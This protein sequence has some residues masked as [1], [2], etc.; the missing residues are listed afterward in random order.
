MWKSVALYLV[1]VLLPQIADG[2]GP[3]LSTGAWFRMEIRETGIYKLDRNFFQNANVPNFSSINAIRIFGGDGKALNENPGGP[4]PSAMPEVARYVVDRNNN[5][6]FDAEDFVLFYGRS[7]RWWTYNASTRSFS[8]YLNYYTETNVYYFTFSAGGTPNVMDTIRSEQVSTP[9]QALDVAGKIAVE[10]ELFKLGTNS[11]REWFGRFLNRM[12]NSTTYTTM[13]DGI[14]QTKPILYRFVILSR[15]S[16]VDTFR[17][18]ESGSPLGNPT[19]MFPVDVTSIEGNFAYR[20]P[21]ITATHTGGIPGGRSSLRF[22]FGTR[23]DAAEA[24]IDWFEIHYRQRLEAI[25]DQLVFHTLDTTGIV[26]Y[27]LS[28]FSSGEK[29]VFDVT[30]HAN[31]KRITGIMTLPSDRDVILFQLNQSAGTVR[32]IAVVGQNGFRTPA[33]VARVPNS[34]LREITQGAEFV[35]ISPAEFLSEANRL[36]THRERVNP[37]ST[38][39]VDIQSLFN[40]YSFGIADPTAIRNF[41]LDARAR[42]TRRVNYV[43]LFGDGHYDYKNIRTTTKNW[44]PPYE[45]IESVQQILTYTTDDYFVRLNAGTA[46]PTLRIGRLPIRNREEAAA[47]V[48]KIIR[49]ETAAPFDTWR[50]R[51]TFVADDGLTSTRDDGNI[52][53]LQ[54]DLLA[55][56]YTPRSFEREKIYIVEYPTVNS[57]VG[58]RKPDAN[59]AIIDAFNRGTLIVNFVGH[60]NTKVWTHEAV[61]TQD[62]SFA[63]LAN[64]DRLP[65]LVAATCDFAR[66]DHPNEYSGGEEIV[67]MANRGAIASVTSVRAVYSF[68]N[69]QFNTTF[70]TNLL[71]A[72]DSLGRPVRLGDAMFQTKQALYQIN[73][74]KYHLFGDPTLILAMPRAI[75][76]VDSI[77]SISTANRV[78][79]P[80]LG[81]A[82]VEGTLKRPNNTLWGTFNGRALVEAFDAKRRVVIPGFYSYDKSGSLLYRGE[83]SVTNGRYR[84]TFPIPKDVSYES[85]DARLT[86]YAWSDSSDAVGFT[87]NITIAGTDSTA[88]SDSRGPTIAIYLEDRAFRPGDVVKP[89]ALLLVDLSDESG[90][91]TSTAGVGHR[92]EATLDG[93]R[94]IDLSPFYRGNLDTYQSGEIRYQL[95]DL[96]E[97]RHTMTIKAW[98]VHNN[99]S[100]AETY[101]EVRRGEPFGIF[102]AMNFP[103][104]F[105]RQTVFTFQRNSTAPVDVEVKIY[106]VTGK[107]IQHLE[108]R[109]V[110][111]RFV[112]VPWDGRDRDGQEVANGMYFYKI[113]V[114]SPFEQQSG[115]VVG[116]CAIVR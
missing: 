55:T 6:V 81:R 85:S 9:L 69:F 82:V 87:E 95:T 49:Y 105:S 96:A 41:L 2:Q 98:D 86:V 15:S 54:A 110:I 91:N 23:N 64:A 113:I 115:E 27:S 57:A 33:N 99:S 78:Q 48:D 45:T 83:I 111:D 73:D 8:H 100:T 29:L 32:E 24:W 1:V 36:K 34:N 14:E 19:V 70:F 31:V 44:I 52:H 68:E 5:G 114:R 22:I 21:V 88:P 11:G 62:E 77:N 67:T 7:P 84:A 4:L 76:S 26:Q 61:F 63:K 51:I 58:R 39:V 101:F 107:M 75:V 108:S 42:W 12:N 93:T 65:L 94:A 13:L 20:S 38:L 17:V 104:P 97:G 60:G 112:R 89:E 109:A 37:L 116:K 71:F 30:D 28:K 80:A 66:F 16:T 46:Q 79:L 47:M 53:T 106:T 18:E 103:N 102:N 72:R 40:E 25:N 43:L 10:E 74:Q 90:I 56:S 3:T 35:I 92:L 50:N 59:R